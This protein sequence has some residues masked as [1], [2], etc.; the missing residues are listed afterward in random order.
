MRILFFL[1]LV[2]CAGRAAADT[3]PT[4]VLGAR[5]LRA[6]DAREWASAQALYGIVAD[7][8]PS[9]A[10][11]AARLAVA[12]EARGDSTAARLAVEQAMSHGVA[13]D[14]V[15]ATAR[16]LCFEAAIPGAYTTLLES[17]FQSLPYA[18]RPLAMTLLRYN[19]ARCH[20]SDAIRWADYLL[21]GAPGDASVLILKARAALISND[22]ASAVDCAL[23][24]LQTDPDNLE[25]L[26]IAGN[27][28]AMTHQP[29]ALDLLRRA[30]SLAPTPYLQERIQ[31][32]SGA[33]NASHNRPHRHE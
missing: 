32:L 31:T 13:L 2:L 17:L 10:E 22:T 25:A 8:L 23:Q 14:S 5:A 1:L 9:S 33:K 27:G 15:L 7:R 18:R 30:C 11:A 4:E 12:A 28:K 29:G 6:W 21:L 16:G 20:G 3:T 24:A 26:L 19:L